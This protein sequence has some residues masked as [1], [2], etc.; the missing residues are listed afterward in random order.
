VIRDLIAVITRNGVVLRERAVPRRRCRKD[1][2]IAEVVGAGAAIIASSTWNTRFDGHAVAD[3][4]VSNCGAD[5]DNGAGGLVAQDDGAG[6][7][8][9]ADAAALPVVYVAAAD[10]WGSVSKS[11]TEIP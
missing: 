3:F 8:E 9:V 11:Q 2:V 4:E 7:N 1:C 6:E 5:F 10:T